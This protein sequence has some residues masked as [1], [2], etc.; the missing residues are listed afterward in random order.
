MDKFA[1]HTF[2]M[3]VESVM[4]QKRLSGS[5]QKQKAN[6]M[7]ASIT[8]VLNDGVV[9]EGA[10]HENFSHFENAGRMTFCT[11]WDKEKCMEGT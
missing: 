3:S 9:G 4:T 2:A 6:E 1:P 11:T 5:Q 7:E 8:L 10:M